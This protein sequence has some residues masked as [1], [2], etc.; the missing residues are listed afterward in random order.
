MSRLTSILPKIFSP[1]Q[2]GF[3]KGLAIGH[4]II[5]A[6]EF[7]HD[8]DVKVRGGNIILILDISK[9]YDNID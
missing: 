2:M 3:I 9:S 6:Q 5:L 1:Y 7:F 4:N 8:L